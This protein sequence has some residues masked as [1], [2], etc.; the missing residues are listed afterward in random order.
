MN[1]RRSKLR[2]DQIASVVGRAVIAVPQLAFGCDG[3]QQPVG[4]Q[5]DMVQQPDGTQQTIGAQQVV[6]TQQSGEA[7]HADLLPVSEDADCM[8]LLLFVRGLY[9]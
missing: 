4:A 7:Q 1:R 9:G 8:I 2:C 3:T 5:S 6:G